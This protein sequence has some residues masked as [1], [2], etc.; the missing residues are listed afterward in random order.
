[1]AIHCSLVQRHGWVWWVK[2]GCPS[3]WHPSFTHCHIRRST[4]PPFTIFSGIHSGASA[5]CAEHNCSA[6]SWTG[7]LG[8][9]QACTTESSLVACE[10]VNWVQDR[11]YYTY[12]S[13]ASLHQRG[14]EYFSNIVKLNT[15]QS[16]CWTSIFSCTM[17]T[18]LVVRTWTHL[19]KRPWLHLRS[20]YL[21]PDS[22]PHQEP[23]FCYSCSK[24]LM[25]KFWKFIRFHGT[26]FSSSDYIALDM[27]L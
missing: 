2:G 18:P 6:C 1:M 5:A 20:K 15:D 17:N 25:K 26:L 8:T 16:R 24:I 4:H 22:S 12:Q 11:H 10:G 19:G 3:H 21:N 9:H 23:S 27:A 13:L 14:P 7:L